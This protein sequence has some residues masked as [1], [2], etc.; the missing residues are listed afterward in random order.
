M[1]WLNDFLIWLNTHALWL[2]ALHIF[3][4][5]CWFAGI[6]YLPRLFVNHAMTDNAA[7]AR[8]LT[9]MERKLYRFITPFAV[10]TVLLGLG[11]MATRWDYYLSAAWLQA[12]LALV[13]VLLA[14][15]YYCGRLVRN[16]AREQNRRGH[17]FYRWFNEL[18]VLLLLGIIFLVELQP[19]N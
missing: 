16:F 2:K 18:P 1:P 5:V 13:V 15:H 9:I 12:K 11:L 8:Q 3:F 14:Y 10:L 4:M 19:F 6:F 7:V 17:V